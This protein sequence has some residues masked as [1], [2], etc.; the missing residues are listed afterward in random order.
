M[1]VL[2]DTDALW[3]TDGEIDALADALALIDADK[4]GERL[5]LGLVLALALKDGVGEIEVD[6]DSLGL[7]LW[8]G[9]TLADGDVL[10]LGLREAL[11][12]READAEAESEALDDGERLLSAPG[13]V[14]S[15]SSRPSNLVATAW[16]G[17]VPSTE[18]AT[19]AKVIWRMFPSSAAVWV[20]LPA[21]DQASS[22]AQLR[23]T[24][25][26]VAVAISLPPDCF[27]IVMAVFSSSCVWVAPAASVVTFAVFGFTRV[28]SVKA[29]I[30]ATTS[31]TSAAARVPMISTDVPVAAAPP[32][33]ISVRSTNRC[34]CPLAAATTVAPALI[35]ASVNRVR[36][37]W[38]IPV[39]SI[40]CMCLSSALA[41]GLRH[42]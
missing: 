22:V 2:G 39:R 25:K 10:A 32:T 13:F 1:L 18:S 4:D 40:C 14:T 24:S 9:L 35:C 15:F 31:L 42:G 29:A 33:A 36:T 5:L 7:R 20:T 27:L 28:F 21:T 12:L 6:A 11:P 8:L 34:F 41:G 16:D 19:H 26:W 3:L 17:I 37:L 23:M 30:A 38:T